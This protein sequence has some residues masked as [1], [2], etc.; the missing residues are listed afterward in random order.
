[1]I[2]KMLEKDPQGRYQTAGELL[3]ELRGLQ[4]EGVTDSWPTESDDWQTPE[5]LALVDTKSRATRQLEVT[6]RNESLARA[7]R[8][9]Y[10][11]WIA[12]VA[13]A[14]LVG[15]TI[16]WATRPQPLL[17]VAAQDLPRVTRQDNVVDQ[18]LHAIQIGTVQAWE[19]LEEHFPPEGSEQNRYYA[20]RARQRLAELYVEHDDLQRALHSYRQLADMDP[21]DVS[22]QAIGIIGM[23]NVHMLRGEMSQAKQQLAAFVQLYDRLPPQ[24]RS[25]ITAEINPRLRPELERLSR[26]LRPNHPG[27]RVPPGGQR[28]DPGDARS[29]GRE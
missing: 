7:G 25:Y 29:P 5:L 18:Y 11:W 17:H 2:H 13:V 12:A 27:S 20:L 9:R 10:G 4:I 23:A 16:A 6:M 19:S 3:R 22:F 1:M 14:F 15:G 26:E 21:P 8:S 24:V 28:R